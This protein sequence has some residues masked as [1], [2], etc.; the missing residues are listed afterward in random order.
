MLLAHLDT[1]RIKTGAKINAGDSIGTIG[2]TGL[3][4]GAH[5]HWELRYNGIRLD[6]MGFALAADP[7]LA[8]RVIYAG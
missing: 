1:I 4:F 6:P 2:A 3:A 8:K 7:A 5:I